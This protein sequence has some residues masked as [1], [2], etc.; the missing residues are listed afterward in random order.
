MDVGQKIGPGQDLGISL[1][2]DLEVILNLLLSTGTEVPVN[3]I[4]SLTLKHGEP[5]LR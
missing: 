1:G 2:L 4:T 3:I 5:D